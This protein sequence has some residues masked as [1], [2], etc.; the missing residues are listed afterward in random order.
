MATTMVTIVVT[1]A[2]IM[3]YLVVHPTLLG[4]GVSMSRLIL[5]G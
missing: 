1:A 5:L 4:P 3:S 2:V